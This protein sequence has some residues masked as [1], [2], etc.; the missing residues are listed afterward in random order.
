MPWGT[1][2]TRAKVALGGLYGG[3]VEDK[4]APLSGRSTTWWQ[5]D[6]L[7]APAPKFSRRVFE[8]LRAIWV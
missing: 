2:S 4:F 1:T 5:Y 8:E 7:A 3:L 6:G